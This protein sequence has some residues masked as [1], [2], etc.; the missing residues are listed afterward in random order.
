MYL[1]GVGIGI[2]AAFWTLD[3]YYGDFDYDMPAAFFAITLFLIPI[4]WA[5]PMVGMMAARG[6]AGGV[7]A[8]YQ[9]LFLLQTL[10]AALGTFIFFVAPTIIANLS[11]FSAHK[12]FTY[13]DAR[14]IR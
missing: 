10:G 4:G 9:G 14:G 8:D 11:S 1:I 12:S 2:A 3:K 6:L 5:M 7:S 13:E